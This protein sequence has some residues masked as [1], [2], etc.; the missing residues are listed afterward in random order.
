MTI[1]ALRL[2][3]T[4]PSLQVPFFAASGYLLESCLVTLNKLGVTYTKLPCDIQKHGRIMTACFK[5]HGRS[6]ST[7]FNKLRGDHNKAEHYLINGLISPS[8]QSFVLHG[9][10]QKV[11]FPY[12]FPTASLFY[13]LVPI[14]AHDCSTLIHD[15]KFSK[16]KPAN[17]AFFLHKTINLIATTIALQTFGLAASIGGYV[18]RNIYQYHFISKTSCKE[19]LYSLRKITIEDLVKNSFLFVRFVADAAKNYFYYDPI[20]TFRNLKVTATFKTVSP[21]TY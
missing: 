20:H 10:V 11:V 6:K 4:H 16:M 8:A 14:I 21:E 3:Q 1:Q 12:L 5:S 19:F 9:L 15:C 17:P 13:T 2:L 18:G 7:P